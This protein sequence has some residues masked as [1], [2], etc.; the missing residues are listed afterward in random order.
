MTSITQETQALYQT[1]LLNN[2]KAPEITLARGEG[3]YVW[4]DSGQKYLDFTTG[5]AVNCIGH[6]HPHW[7]E[8]MQQQATT[9]AHTSNLFRNVAQAFLAKRLVEKAGPGKVFFCNSGTEANEAAIKLARLYGGSLSGKDGDRYTI[10]TAENSFHGRTFG[11]MAATGQEKIQKGF[12]PMLPGFLNAKLNDLS[13]FEALID[14]RTTAIFLETIQGEGGIWPCEEQFLQG[15][16]QLC[17][18]HNILLILDEVQCGS[19]R[20]GNYFAYERYHIHPDAVVMAKGL[21]G[22]FPIGALWVAE[23]HT[24]LFQPGMHGSTFGGGP[25]ACAAALATM[26][27]IEKECLLDRVQQQSPKWIS[28]LNQLQKKYSQHIKEIRGLG[29]IIGMEMAREN[30]SFIGKL[31]ESGLLVVPSGLHTIRLFPPLT[32]TSQELEQSIAIME[33]VLSEQ[34]K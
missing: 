2:Y 26:D 17:D 13:S 14:D 30:A 7:V 21:A 24:A 5:I 27:V 34:N 4:D 32:A 3:S 31:R 18:T 11:G 33:M 9:L 19:G 25:L 15:I 22:G 12:R 1:Y 20:T 10:I 16:R 8:K 28:D 29:Y 6:R 23:K